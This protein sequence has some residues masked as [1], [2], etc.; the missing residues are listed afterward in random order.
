MRCARPMATTIA[1]CRPGFVI[2]PPALQTRLFQVNYIDLERRGTSRTRVASGQVGQSSNAAD[3]RRSGAV[4]AGG[5][6]I[7]RPGLERA[8]GLGV[9][10]LGVEKWRITSRRSPGTQR[11]D[12]LLLGFLA[13]AREEP[14]RA[15]SAA[16]AAAPSS[17]TPSQASSPCARRR[18]NCATC[19]NISTRSSRSRPSQVIIEAKIIEV[20]LVERLPGRHQLGC[21]RA[22]SGNSTY[23]RDF[24]PGRSKGFRHPDSYATT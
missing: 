1:A 16:T 4:D 15:R 22:P 6:A 21:H 20:T 24:R 9:R 17:S 14:A 3:Q 10:P 2:D 8:A 5:D 7:R 19:S 12:A 13:G 11:L 23:Q 18:G